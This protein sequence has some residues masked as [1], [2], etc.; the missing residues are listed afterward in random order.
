MMLCKH[1]IQYCR[2]NFDLEYTKYQNIK[3]L[4]DDMDFI[5]QFGDIPSE[6]DA[7]G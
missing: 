2:N 1:I 3:E 6:E 4:Q 5:K 7:V